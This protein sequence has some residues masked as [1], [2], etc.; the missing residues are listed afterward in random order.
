MD[1]SA[2]PIGRTASLGPSSDRVD[3][4]YSKVNAG[5]GVLHN[6]GSPLTHHPRLSMLGGWSSRTPE[7][8]TMPCLLAAADDRSA[9][10]MP[11]RLF[12]NVVGAASDDF[13]CGTPFRNFAGATSDD[14]MIYGCAGLDRTQSGHPAVTA[15]TSEAVSTALH[16]KRAY[17]KTRP[18]IELSVSGPIS[19]SK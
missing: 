16:L 11:R 2:L 1:G 5:F 15:T 17:D 10:A 18:R 13:T 12:R 4:G 7:G 14:F 8:N 9:L 19:N 3:L 6:F